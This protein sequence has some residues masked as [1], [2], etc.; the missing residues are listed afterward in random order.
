MINN[1]KIAFVT[2]VYVDNNFTSGGVKLNYILLEGLK[3]YGYQIDLFCGK[4]LIKHSEIFNNLYKINEFE[5]VRYNYDVIISDKACV[6]SDITYIH[7]HSYFYRKKMMFD[8]TGYFL[9][10]IFCK[11]HHQKR[12]T[13]FFKIRDNI[14]KCKRVVVSSEILKR[15]LI[16]NYGCDENKIIIIPPPVEKY[17][18]NHIP[19]KVFTFGISAIGFERKGGYILLNAMKRLIKK[20]ANFK[21]KFIYPNKNL[22]VK[23]FVRFYGLGKF[24]EFLPIQN[25]MGDFYNSID[26]LVMPSIIEPFGMVAAEALGAGCPVITASHCGAADYVQ[27]GVNGYIYERNSAYN[28][29]EVMLKVLNTPCSDYLKLRENAVVSV[30]DLCVENFIKRIIAAI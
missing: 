21:V 30:K 12:L 26:C 6:I 3:K 14:L 22:A 11:K 10:R 2:N 4:L 7:D 23:F 19:N 8:N 5:N 16:D 17:L 20:N 9:Y 25:N 28:L 15:D 13:E 24:C 18:I 29:A 1:K 27:E